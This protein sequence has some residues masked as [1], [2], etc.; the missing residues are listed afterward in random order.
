MFT[1]LLLI[2]ARLVL[3]ISN[4]AFAYEAVVK[5]LLA[6]CSTDAVVQANETEQQPLSDMILT[7]AIETSGS[8]IYERLKKLCN[9]IQ[10]YISTLCKSSEPSTSTTEASEAADKKQEEDL[11]DLLKIGSLVTELIEKRKSVM[12]RA[13]MNVPLGIKTQQEAV[14]EEEQMDEQR[15]YDIVT[16]VS[17]YTTGRP[18]E[19]VYMEILKKSQ[20]QTVNFFNTDGITTLFPFHYSS[21]IGALAKVGGSQRIRR[22]AQESASLLNSLPLSLSSSVFVCVSEERLDTMKVLI[23][24]PADTPY[25]GGCFEFDIFFPLDFPN[26]PPQ[27]NLQ[28]TGNRSVRFNP[29]LYDDGKVCLSILNTWSGRPEERW[30]TNSSLLQ[31]LVSIQSLILVP[32]P[33]FN[34]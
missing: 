10:I 22:L 24:G 20:Y 33:F 34:G 17:G 25:S 31:V 13:F 30:N 19:V 5:L 32:E 28:T 9:C 29:N 12:E 3:D 6:I 27:M 1:R 2:I 14:E 21:S 15:Q 26:V 7:N 16:D 11:A 8:S 23:T 4:H 18:L